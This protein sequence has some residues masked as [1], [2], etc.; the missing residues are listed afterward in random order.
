MWLPNQGG[1]APDGTI[2]WGWL[3]KAGFAA[4]GQPDIAAWSHRS[5]VGGDLT[6]KPHSWPEAWYNHALGRYVWPAFLGNDASTPDEEVY[7]V[8]DDYTN[9]S[10][11]TTPSP[12][13]PPNGASVSTWRCRF[14]QFNN[15][16]A[17]DII[18]LVYRVTN[19]SPKTI[20]KVYFGM[21]GDPHVGGPADYG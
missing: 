5:D 11:S 18:F 7:F 6:R 19:R 12:T 10:T 15:P 8:C 1:Y 4:P 17:E 16:L 2:K 21:Y 20:N 13:T 3:P 14:F 9:G